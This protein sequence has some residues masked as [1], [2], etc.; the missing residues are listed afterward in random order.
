MNMLVLGVIDIETTLDGLHDDAALLTKASERQFQQELALQLKTCVIARMRPFTRIEILAALLDPELKSIPKVR[1]EVPRGDP[2]SFLQEAVQDFVSE[3]G[4][5]DEITIVTEPP[6]KQR[7]ATLLA[8][9]A[10][11]ARSAPSSETEIELYLASP[12]SLKSQN[13]GGEGVLAWWASNAKVYPS[14]VGLARKILSI[15]ATSA[16]PERRFSAAGNAVRE[17]RCRLDPTTMAMTL[18]IHDNRRFL[19]NS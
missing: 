5:D 9:Y 4:P 11:S 1:E 18:F 14:L 2:A 7:R 12:V 19:P 15:P 17:K 8:K 10:S 13:A 16:E 3:R 6:P